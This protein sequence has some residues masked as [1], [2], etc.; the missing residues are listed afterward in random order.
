[1]G[2][3]EVVA[4]VDDD[5]RGIPM[6]SLAGQGG[7][8]R[9]L[10]VDRLFL[11]EVVRQATMFNVAFERAWL[12]AVDTGTPYQDLLVLAD[13]Q[14][15][16]FAAI[17][18]RRILKPEGVRKHPQHSK[19]AESQ[20]YADE[21]GLR[22]RM[23]L[24]LNEGSPIFTVR[25]LRNSYEHIDE[26]I[27]ALS[28]GDAA[29]VSDWSISDGKGFRTVQESS[30]VHHRLRVFYP[31]AGVLFYDDEFIDLYHL[32]LEMMSVR[33][34]AESAIDQLSDPASRQPW[35]FGGSQLVHLVEPKRVQTRHR[36]WMDS[37]AGLGGPIKTEFVIGFPEPQ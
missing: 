10:A 29:S 13:V 24:G 5:P 31:A 27:D 4:S 25:E 17:I 36:E 6:H 19:Q 23:Q 32:D 3:I 8:G 20:Q 14:S 35:L 33:L 34:Q 22:L 18:I 7:E 2:L 28:L 21:R 12:R 30:G 9:E 37:R 1:M 16:L 11:K 15:A 26:R